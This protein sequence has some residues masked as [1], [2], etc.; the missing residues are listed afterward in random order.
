MELLSLCGSGRAEGL[1]APATERGCRGE[2][3]QECWPESGSWGARDGPELSLDEEGRN[4]SNRQYKSPL[5]GLRKSSSLGC[6][7]QMQIIFAKTGGPTGQNGPF[8]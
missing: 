6:S 3:T 2:A 8:C 1:G 7:G 5:P 4:L